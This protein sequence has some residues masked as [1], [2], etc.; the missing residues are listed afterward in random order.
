M[1]CNFLFRMRGPGAEFSDV[2]GGRPLDIF[3]KDFA[4]SNKTE[5]SDDMFQ[6]CTER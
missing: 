2:F 1:V 6:R 5:A 4:K 3:E